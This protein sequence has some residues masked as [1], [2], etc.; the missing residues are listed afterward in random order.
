MILSPLELAQRA[1]RRVRSMSGRLRWSIKVS[2][3]VG[4]EG[5]I[6][7]D[8]A[9]AEDLAAALRRL[10]QRV[11][12]DRLDAPL[13]SSMAPWDDAVIW[14]RGL[15]EPSLTANAANMLWVISHPDLVEDQELL[16]GWHQIYAA[17][18]A[19]SKQRTE[20]VGVE[21]RP[22]LQAVSRD[23]FAPEGPSEP[24]EV[25]FVGTTRGIPRPVILDAVLVGAEVEIFG[26][27]WADY[28]EKR[29]IHA[30]RMDFEAVP[31][32]YRGA[33]RIL[34]DHWD[35]MRINGFVSNRLFD[36]VAS[37]ACVVTD[38]VAGIDQLF[39]PMVQTYETLDELA[40]ILAEDRYWPNQSCRLKIAHQVLI[41]HSFDARAA[42]LLGD[43]LPVFRS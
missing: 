14:L 26:H 9:F 28:V 41:E 25:L 42:V 8:V 11:R 36:A 1:A 33:R 40:E 19:W 21:V 30:D 17:S 43:A 29:Y 5:D 13:R 10:G 18:E 7:G 3:P 12:V 34:N 15:A 37:G 38:K 16:Q 23:R 2:A 39:G 32:A 35:D 27:G 6:W 20:D 31:A 22:L 24:H 4:T